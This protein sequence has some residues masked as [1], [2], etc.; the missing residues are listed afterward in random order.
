MITIKSEILDIPNK[1]EKLKITATDECT[2]RTIL[3][4]ISLLPGTANRVYKGSI[5][6]E[7]PFYGPLSTVTNTLLNKLSKIFQTQSIHSAQNELRNQIKKHR[8][9]TY[10]S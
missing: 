5:P 3:A 8:N 9:M 7:P 1:Y 2:G 10:V 4:S 6:T